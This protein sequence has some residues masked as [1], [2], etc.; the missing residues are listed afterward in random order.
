MEGPPQ[1]VSIEPQFFIPQPRPEARSR[2]FCFPHAGGSPIFFFDW[3][4][5]LGPEIECVCVQY[6]GRGSRLREKPLFSVHDLVEEIGKGFPAIVE[7]PFTLYGHSFGGIVAFELTR[8][9]R[10]FGYPL[11]N[12]LFV[13]ATRPP[14]LES[15]FSPIH[16]L[17]DDKF[18]EAIQ[19]RYGGIPPA[20]YRSPELLEIFLPA[21]RADFTAYETYCFQPNEPLDLPICAFAG[22]NDT[23][24]ATASV[25]EWSLHTRAGFDINVYPGGHFFPATSGL[26]LVCALQAYIDALQNGQNSTLAN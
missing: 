8:K 14:H 11:P 25:R 7:K 4:E 24:V 12:Q 6:P 23:A 26:D 16:G 9:L 5:R 18:V 10:N 15:P 22:A 20:I 19:T 1:S 2:L 17:P 21:M 3:A 13:G